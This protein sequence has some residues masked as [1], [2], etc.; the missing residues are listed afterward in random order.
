[1]T[2]GRPRRAPDAWWVPN[3]RVSRAAALAVPL[4]QPYRQA[5][6]EKL[7]RLLE[8]AGKRAA[9]AAVQ[10]YLETNENAILTE[11]FP[12]GWADQIL[13]TGAVGMLVMSGD[14]VGADPA[15]AAL[16]AEAL[17]ENRELDL[18]TFLSVAPS[19]RTLD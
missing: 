2:R 6:R 16:A 10:A 18:E 13:S 1:M 12:D 14:P 8:K 17:E 5:I 9:K 19:D 3:L 11:D 15:D 4:G 7:V